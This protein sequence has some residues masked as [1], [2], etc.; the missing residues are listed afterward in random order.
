MKRAQE[1]LAWEKLEHAD[2]TA[3]GRRRK[4]SKSRYA[5][6]SSFVSESPIMKDKYNDVELP[7]D[8]ATKEKLLKA[9]VPKRLANHVAHLF[10]RDPLV[11]FKEAVDV[12]DSKTTEHFENVQSTNWQSVQWKPPP[13]NAD[14]GWRVELRTMETQVRH[15]VAAAFVGCDG[16]LTRALLLLLLLLLLFPLPVHGL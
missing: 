1:P 5:S 14:M 7:V 2:E 15:L 16:E 13:P 8:E 12:D 11:I 10:T 4:L 6:I 9:G 3:G